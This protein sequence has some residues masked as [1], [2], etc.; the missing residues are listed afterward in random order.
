MTVARHKIICM[1]LTINIVLYIASLFLVSYSCYFDGVKGEI[2][3]VFFTTVP[4]LLVLTINIVLY[5]LTWIRLRT[6]AKRLKYVLGKDAKTVR[7]SHGAARTMSLFVVAFFVQWWA[8]AVYGIW[9]LATDDVPQ[10]LFQFVTTYSNIGGI[11]NGI[12]YIIIRRRKSSATKDNKESSREDIVSQDSGK[13]P[14]V[15]LDNLNAS[16]S[17]TL[18]KY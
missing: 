10:L 16:Y 6:E 11:L 18:E 17:K 12:V 8:M 7:A 2:A 9:Q 5:I 4:L 15:S 3:N 13:G 14:S 1:R